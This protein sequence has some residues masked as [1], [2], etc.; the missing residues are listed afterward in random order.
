MSDLEVKMKDVGDYW[1]QKMPMMAME[2][3]AELIQ[4]ISKFERADI[5]IEDRNGENSLYNNLVKEM[6]DVY[7]S[8]HALMWWYTSNDS[9]YEVMKDDV[10][11]A[12]VAKLNK[13]Y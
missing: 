3:C 4:A 7:I 6:A 11:D 1:N 8:I 13:K 2:E 9:M 10:A 12:I 5:V